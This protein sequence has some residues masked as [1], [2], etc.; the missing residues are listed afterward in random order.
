MCLIFY[1]VRLR[2]VNNDIS[3]IKPLGA[4]SVDAAAFDVSNCIYNTKLLAAALFKKK[5]CY[6]RPNGHAVIN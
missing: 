4:V 6:N 2:K 5:H 3:N 1:K